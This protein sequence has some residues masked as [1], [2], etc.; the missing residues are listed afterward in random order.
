MKRSKPIV[1]ACGLT[2]ISAYSHNW[3]KRLDLPVG[4]GGRWFLLCLI[5]AKLVC[6]QRWEDKDFSPA[7][8][9]VGG[10]G[11]GG[12]SPYP[13]SVWRPDVQG[14]IVDDLAGVDFR[15]GKG[16]FAT[17]NIS[18]N[19]A[20]TFMNHA[21]EW[22]IFRKCLPL[23]TKDSFIVAGQTEEG[24]IGDGFCPP[25]F[26]DHFNDLHVLLDACANEV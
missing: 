21:Y 10:G 22:H 5:E 26:S 11:G 4:T 14:I 9:K 1:D 8:T 13:C 20:M 23:F 25:I 7:A 17:R 15:T 2:R 16:S 24:I 18:N 19:N 3:Q 12:G 6:C